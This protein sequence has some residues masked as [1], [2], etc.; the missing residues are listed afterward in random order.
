MSYLPLEF[1]AQRWGAQV[2]GDLSAGAAREWLV[3]DGCGGYAMGTV[4]GL[5][6]RRYHALLV[7]SGAHPGDRRVA[8]TSI[9]PVLEV[10]GAS[11]ALGV[12]EWASSAISPNGYEFLESFTLRDGLP[13]WRWRIGETV[14][15][16]S[17][18]MVHGRCAIGVVHRLLAGPPVTLTLHAAGTW[19]DAHGERY[20]S[21]PAPTM[22]TVAD[23]VVV[24][25][26]Y[27]LA[28]PAFAAAGSWW[29]GAHLREEAAR[30]LAADEDLWSIGS[31]TRTLTAGE[32]LEITAWVGDVDD[33]PASAPEIITAEIGRRRSLL[34][35][36]AV[37]GDLDATLA[38]AA[39]AFVIA[40][41][42]IVAGYPW[43]GA[44]SRDTMTSYEGLI[45]T[46]NRADEGR[47]L[48]RRYASAVSDGM[49]PNTAD[50]STPGAIDFHSVDAP[51]WFIHAVG[52]HVAIAGD[53]DLG[54]ELR[55]VLSSII[56]AYAAGTRFGIGTNARGLI[57]AGAPDTSLTWMDARVD[58]KP[59]T[60][61]WGSPVEINALWINALGVMNTL[62]AD[63]GAR[64][65]AAITAFT[66]AFVPS[67][68]SLPDVVASDGTD[69]SIRPNQL[70]AYALPYGPLHG[71]PVGDA[72]GAQ[73]LT[74][75]GLRTL[76]PDAPGYRGQHLGDGRTRDLAY[77]QGTVWPWM[78]GPYVLAR[79][80]AGQPIDGLLDGLSAHLG[81]YGLGSVS[82]TACG[83]APHVA[84][85]CPFQAWSVAQTWMAYQLG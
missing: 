23:G 14:L 44:W 27:R 26:A 85:G 76:A 15:E 4:S 24:D 38:L 50:T 82:E 48:L 6:T 72:V 62:G 45:L 67:G 80:A 12:N 22:E 55:P 11:V 28:G 32:S 73:L 68:G 81:E 71:Q 60:S 78:I 75:L 19:R 77:H 66:S 84:T 7:A 52:R 69:A 13:Y 46:A 16:R 63:L 70:L 8:L 42:D 40:G 39:D 57:T 10:N 51:L 47:D 36:A 18:A 1:N 59:V 5:R 29:R 61:R 33:R 34:H 41:P 17:L 37:R 35:T 56:D 9:D 21:G 58:G 79:H 30:G 83:D 43:F 3:P 74:P 20:A 53:I 25:G 49:L 65:D 54:Q 2:C 31:F 64:R